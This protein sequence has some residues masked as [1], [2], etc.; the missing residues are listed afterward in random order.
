MISKYFTGRL[1][2]VIILKNLF[3]QGDLKQ[4]ILCSLSEFSLMNIRSSQDRGEWGSLFL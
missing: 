3:M 4:G 1:I 2:F